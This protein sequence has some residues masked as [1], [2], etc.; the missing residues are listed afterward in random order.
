MKKKILVHIVIYGND[1]NLKKCVDS[2]F[3]QEDKENVF[4]LDIDVTY[5][6]KEG[7]NEFIADVAKYRFFSNRFNFGFAAAHNQGA[8]RFINSDYDYF[9]VLNADCILS[10]TAIINL[11]YEF[12]SD[13]VGAV[14]P[15]LLR[16]DDTLQPMIPKIIDS[17]GIVFTRTFR[18]FDRNSGK[19]DSDN[20]NKSD[21][22]TG[23]TGACILMNKKFICDVSWD[24]LL[25]ETEV[26]KLYPFLKLGRSQRTFLFDE[27]YFAYREDADLGLR[28][29]RLGWRF[30]Y[31]AAAIG[32]HKRVVSPENRRLV[33]A[34]INRL[35][36]RNRFLLQLNNFIFD[37]DWRA[38]I[39]GVFF[40]NFIVLFGVFIIERSSVSALSD[41]RILLRRA[42]ERRK[43]LILEIKQ[44][45]E[46]T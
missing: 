39:P 4:I 37:Y 12:D 44:R 38:L 28:A 21:Y 1:P 17:T 23:L 24:N 2:L 7:D 46:Q 42:L 3:N 10:N 18:H 15:K 8:F 14:G 40:R 22:V 33:S 19:P 35:G 5:N 26:D 45:N 27:A 43:R 16:A 25:Y 34:E 6:P 31:V 36:V 32:Y 41:L 13:K 20:Y 29:T 9:M 11:I 30:K